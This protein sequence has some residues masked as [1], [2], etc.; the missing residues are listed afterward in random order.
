LWLNE[1]GLDIRCVRMK[2]YAYDGRLLID[3]QQVIPLP[4]AEEYQ[5]RIR[6]KEQR[7]RVARQERSTLDSVFVPFWTELLAYARART[8]L[9]AGSTPRTYYVS[10]SAKAA[11]SGLY[12]NYVIGR[13][14]ARVEL[15]IFRSQEESKRVFDQLAAAREEIE[16]RFGEPLDW[17]RLDQKKICRICR[18]F[19]AKI[20]DEATWPELIERLV[21]SMIRLEG[22]LRPHLDRLTLS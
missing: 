13:G 20:R 6:A 8:P 10:Q 19:P 15:G 16:A 9:H 1:R 14:A 18:E 17:Q 12:L 2:P 7:E 21:A 4:E 22:A 11:V 3:V 5:V